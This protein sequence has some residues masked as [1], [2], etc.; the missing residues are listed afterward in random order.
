M[1]LEE[2][3]AK[4]FHLADGTAALDYNRS[5]VPL[6]EIVSEPDFRDADECV[7]YLDELRRLLQRLAVSE[8]AME[9]G[10]F[11]CEPNVSVRRTGEQGLRTKT[12][13]KNLNS[14]STVRR[15]V[16]AEAQRQIELY[17]RQQEVQQATLRYDEARGIT[18]P[19]RVKEIIRRL[20]VLR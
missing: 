2:D 1:H 18:I 15:A 3:T 17:E 13:V 10:N 9:A 4:L 20:P 11:R 6:I 12:E 16:E 19:M 5:G 7:S 8:A 14:F